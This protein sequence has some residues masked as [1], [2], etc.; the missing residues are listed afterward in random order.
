MFSPLIIGLFAAPLV[1]AAFYDLGTYRIPNLLTL[2]LAGAFPIAA[3]LAPGPVDW[4]WHGGAGAVALLVG[5]VLFARRWMGGGDVKLIAACALWMGPLAPTFLV[6]MAVAGGVMGLGLLVVRRVVPG[7][8]MLLPD[9]LAL[10]RVLS[11]GAAIP[12]GVA[13][14]AAGLFLARQLPLVQP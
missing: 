4:L 7:V 11:P 9:G 6:V 13:I 5:A 3:L 14:A 2:A 8:W 1:V 10:P 12:Y